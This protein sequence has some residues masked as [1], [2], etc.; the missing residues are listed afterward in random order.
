MLPAMTRATPLPA[1]ARLAESVGHR[2]HQRV[3][4][5]E[6]DLDAEADK[7]GEG[8]ERQR[9]TPSSRTG[10]SS[11]QIT[12]SSPPKV[13]P[14]SMRK[15]P[16]MLSR[17]SSVE[18]W[19]CSVYLA[20]YV[21]A[22]PEQAQQHRHDEARHRS[23]EVQRPQSGRLHT[24]PPRDRLYGST[25]DGVSQ[26]IGDTKA[27][28]PE[29]TFQIRSSCRML[30]IRLSA[31][32]ICAHRIPLAAQPGRLRARPL[33]FG[34]RRGLETIVLRG[35]ADSREAARAA[36][37]LFS[38]VWYSVRICLQLLHG[39]SP[40]VRMDQ[41][42]ERGQEDHERRTPRSP[43]PSETATGPQTSCRR[44]SPR[45]RRSLRRL[46]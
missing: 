6:D 8:A 4:Q 36:L 11:V 39:P 26:V 1:S 44:A 14:S 3:H 25:P 27:R 16:W 45:S 46:A 22:G 42:H 43:V 32:A 33:S 19:I 13:A 37:I 7:E 15:V 41:Q 28:R 9:D 20:K 18:V 29:I 23:Q 34:R 10:W 38:A 30:C 24:P 35:A 5:A 17:A 21:D 40:P 31:S 12:P 2:P